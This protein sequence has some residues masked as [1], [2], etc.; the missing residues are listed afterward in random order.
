MSKQPCICTHLYRNPKCTSDT[1][2]NIKI[3]LPKGCIGIM[4]VFE[5]KTAARKWQGPKASLVRIDLE[6]MI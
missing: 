3:G 6:K 5:S 1:S 2:L 4:F